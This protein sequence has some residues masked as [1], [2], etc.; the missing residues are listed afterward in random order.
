MTNRTIVAP[1]IVERAGDCRVPRLSA[2]LHSLDVVLASQPDE[3]TLIAAAMQAMTE[4]VAKDDWL[5]AESEQSHP[6]HYRQYLLYR[7]ALQRFSVVSF[8]W[9]P[10]QATPIHDHQTWGVIGM[11]RGSEISQKFRVTAHGV[12]PA[13]PE[14]YLRPGDV[15]SVSPHSG[16]I[17]RVRNAL[18]DKVSISIHVYGTDIGRQ[19]RYVFDSNT[20]AAKEF[21]SGYSNA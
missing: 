8:V 13:G 12:E 21:V 15:T 19:R 10:G 2:F 6:Q 18:N 1:D 9:G 4:L 14:L 11:L 5:P 3:S 16:D 20:G 7:D 17:H